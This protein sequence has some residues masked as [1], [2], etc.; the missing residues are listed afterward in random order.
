METLL[1]SPWSIGKFMNCFGQL[2]TEIEWERRPDAPRCERWMRSDKLEPYTYGR[3]KGQRTY[4]AQ[5]MPPEV[6]RIGYACGQMFG[7]IPP[8]SC[9]ANKYLNN[10]DHLGW[11]SDDD[12]NID[13]R[14]P[15]LSV[16]FGQE[17]KIEFR[18]KP[19]DQEDFEA[20]QNITE[21]LMECGSVTYMPPGFQQTHQHRIPK[22]NFEMEPRIS[23]T[24]R[25]LK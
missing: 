8:N 13:H 25:W 19:R 7:I 24:Y 1:N 17:R 16:S 21:V 2:D 4:E 12:P 22:G 10:R 23:L 14:F 5:Y 15:I 11:H 18:R 3:G 20:V 6:K 9:F